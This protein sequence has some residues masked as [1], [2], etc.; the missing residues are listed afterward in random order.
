[1]NV[2]LNRKNIPHELFDMEEAFNTACESGQLEIVEILSEN[3]D[4]RLLNLKTAMN[5]A[6]RSRMNERLVRFLLDKFDNEKFEMDKVNFAVQ[7][8]E[9]QDITKTY[10]DFVQIW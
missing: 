3:V 5:K 2:I 6:C 4:V 8:Y 1:M 10:R 7:E 9:W